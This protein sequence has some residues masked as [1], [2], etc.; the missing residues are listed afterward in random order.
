MALP[1]YEMTISDDMAS[2][3]EVTAIALVDEPAIMVNWQAF[4]TQPGRMNF[5]TVSDDERLIIGPAMIPDMKIYRNDT[6][7]NGLG[8]Y[9]VFF[10]K[11]T[12]KKIAEK[13]YAKGFQGSANIMHDAGQKVD[14]VNYFLSWIKDDAKGMIGLS[15]DYPN[16]TWFVGARVNNSDAWAKVKSGAIKGFS[17]EGMFEYTATQ[18]VE[19]DTL[20]AD[21]LM[22]KIKEILNGIND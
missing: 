12:V 16:G 1:L 20:A 9:N 6:E 22:Q 13:Y 19:P 11:D 14:G 15:G 2:D 3:L 4:K 17:V 8:E 7:A 10:S 18:V 21:A 5:A